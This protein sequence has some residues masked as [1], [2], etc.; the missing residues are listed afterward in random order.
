MHRGWR[1]PR[2]LCWSFFF[3]ASSG[4]HRLY[5][6]ADSMDDIQARIG[7][8][9]DGRNRMD[10]A[11]LSRQF[12]GRKF[13]ELVLNHYERHDLAATIAAVEGLRDMLPPAARPTVPSWIDTVARQGA[14]PEFWRRDCG[15]VFTEICDRAR[16]WLAKCS[17]DATDDDVFMMAQ[18]IVSNFAYGA[19]TNLGT[20]AFIQK[21]IGI[22]FLRRLLS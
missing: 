7:E 18:I 22:G 17:V 21:S 2:R 9:L 1:T 16:Q 15:E 20:K 11:T 3:V 4:R 10:P 12:A 6:N 19:H 14:N 5:I 13:G 8:K